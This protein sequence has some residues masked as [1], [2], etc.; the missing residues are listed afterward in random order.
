L[1]GRRGLPYVGEVLRR[2]AAGVALASLL[3][4]SSL[5][6]CW[7]QVASAWSPGH[8]C[9]S[10]GE[11]QAA[12]AK[13]C[14]S[15]VAH[16]TVVKLAPPPAVTLPASWSELAPLDLPCGLPPSGRSAS[17]PPPLVLRI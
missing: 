13:A 8:D 2:S 12:P 5:G 1:T 4:C 16:E 14:A 17:P 10:K 9:C 6:L 3:A 15:L 7:R 11:S